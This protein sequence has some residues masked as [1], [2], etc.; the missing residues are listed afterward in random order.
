MAYKHKRARR[1]ILLAVG[2][3]TLMLLACCFIACNQAND[4][5]DTDTTLQT[6]PTDRESDP[7]SDDTQVPTEPAETTTDDTQPEVT[8]ATSDGEETVTQAV[9]TD[10]ESENGGGNVVTLAPPEPVTEPELEIEGSDIPKEE[11]PRIDIRTEGG[12]SIHSKDYYVNSTIS[13]SRCD[14]AY[15]LTDCAAGVR[16]RG[17]STAGAPKKLVLQ[18]PAGLRALPHQV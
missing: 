15:V 12:Q 4:P 17:N 2:L 7:I 5:S 13:V 11:M 6:S 9:E 8:T 16:V 10:E 14:E 18:G 1:C 3:A